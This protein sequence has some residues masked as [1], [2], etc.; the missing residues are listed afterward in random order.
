MTIYEIK[1]R[2][3]ET[4]PYYFT[5]KTLKFFHQTM[6]SFKVYKQSDGRFLISAPMKDY[7]GKVVG[8]SERYF[9]PINNELE[10]N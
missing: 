3:S 8:H 1:Q 4:S 5:P 6:R 2:T 7:T 9:N 10:H